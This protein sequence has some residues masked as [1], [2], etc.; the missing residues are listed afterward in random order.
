MGG[1]PR[2]GPSAAVNLTGILL[3]GVATLYVQRRM[4]VRRRRAHLDD[5]A[6]ES[7]G[8]PIGHSRRGRGPS[9]GVPSQ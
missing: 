5:S 4:Y 2:R 8:L 3:A 6:R 1:I 9:K 7:A